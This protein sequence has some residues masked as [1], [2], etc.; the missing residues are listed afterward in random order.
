MTSKRNAVHAKDLLNWAI[1]ASNALDACLANFRSTHLP[2]SEM[3][4]LLPLL[5]EGP[6]AKEV[7]RLVDE[8][9]ERT[10]AKIIIASGGTIDG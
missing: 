7:E 9:E 10:K 1:E 4:N 6:V 8:L 3:R 5:P 2:I